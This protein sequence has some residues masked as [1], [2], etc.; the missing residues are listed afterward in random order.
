MYQSQIS[1]IEQEYAADISDL[2]AGQTYASMTKYYD[3]QRGEQLSYLKGASSYH[4]VGDD[5]G[6]DPT[7]KTDPL[8]LSKADKELYA[9]GTATQ[10]M[11]DD[12]ESMTR[13]LTDPDAAKALDQRIADIEAMGV[14]DWYTEQFGSPETKL[15]A[16][17]KL[18]KEAAA[19]GKA[20]E[21]AAAGI[22]QRGAAAGGQEPTESPWW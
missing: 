10:M 4:P 22:K 13:E 19:S 15:S 1:R 16:A 11:G 5:D 20:A 17:Q 14:E 7:A 9:A 18:E 8:S 12:P 2:E 6:Y 3:Q 21:E